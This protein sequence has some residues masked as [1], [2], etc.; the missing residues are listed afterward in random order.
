MALDKEART[1]LFGTPVLSR[2]IRKCVQG[3]QC[4]AEKELR[5]IFQDVG[6]NL[7]NQTL[8]QLNKQGVLVRKDGNVS[9]LNDA[10]ALQG[11]QADRAWKAALLLRTFSLEEL[12]RTAE[13]KWS[14][15]QK[16]MS[17]WVRKGLAV[18][19]Q[20]SRSKAPAI[21]SMEA[22]NPPVRPITRRK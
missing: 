20:P 22:K 12:C 16:L 5:E 14:Y 17:V 21:W 13:I 6:S 10:P 8:R 11:S 9:F 18:K 1:T 4:I 19:L 2:Q 7:Y 15:A 3:K